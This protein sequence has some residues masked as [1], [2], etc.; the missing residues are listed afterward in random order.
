MLLDE[1]FGNRNF[2]RL[3]SYINTSYQ[4]DLL[5]PNTTNYLLWYARD[6]DVVKVRHVFL[7][8]QLGDDRAG[9][10]KWAWMPSGEKRA[11]T[12]DE[13]SGRSPLPDG[14]RPF[15][16]G[17]LTSQGIRIRRVATIHFS[18]TILFTRCQSSL[19]SQPRWTRKLGQQRPPDCT[20]EQPSY[21]MFLD[22]SWF[23]H[24]KC[25]ERH[26]M[27]VRRVGIR[28]TLFRRT[29]RWFSGAC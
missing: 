28:C 5:L 1:V 12:A 23:P 27:G 14:A 19:A 16:Y 24:H 11:L 3:I 20:R 10:Y 4:A 29:P 7:P 21:P 17:P 6:V 9:E 18:R 25:L 8:K 13:L 2:C 26:E 22:A 15:R